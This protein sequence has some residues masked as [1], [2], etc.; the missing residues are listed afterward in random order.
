MDYSNWPLKTIKISDLFL[1]SDNI[2]LDITDPISQDA[3]IN[4]LFANENAIE[5]LENIAINGFFPDELPVALMENNKYIVLEG[6]RRIAAL[7]AL[8]RPEIIPFLEKKIKTII[9]SSALPTEEIKVIM[10]PDRDSAMR[11]LAN[12]HTQITRKPWSPLRQAYFY[13][14]EIDRGKTIQDLRNDYPTVDINKFL[15]MTNMHK[16]VKSI[17]YDSKAIAIKAYSEREFPISTLERMYADK[18][19]RDFLGFELTG[20]GDFEIKIKPDEFKKGLKKIIQDIVEK[21]EN[22]RSLNDEES[23]KKYINSFSA[24]DTPDKTKGTKAIKSGGFKEIPINSNSSKQ[25]RRKLA[26]G[27]IIF[28][29]NSPGVERMLR[30]LQAIDYNRFPNAAHDLLR[31]FLECS[32]KEYFYYI[33]DPIRPAKGRS[34]VFLKDVLKALKDKMDL[35]KNTELSQVTQKIISSEAMEP[36]STKMFDAINHNPSIFS[37]PK[38]VE[39]A[40]DSMEKL[41]RFI[42]NPIIKN[43]QNQP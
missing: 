2:R 33:G 12:K 40:W 9:K 29:L 22:S 41:L 1:D 6:N 17:K 8:A 14:A 13:K 28:T 23:R 16:I 31:S 10:A 7:K 27:N 43:A 42:L 34:Y 39:D 21:K 4:D 30:E 5:I 26:P 11:L 37:I 25:K 32:I 20:D 24:A 15:R 35:E 3:I 18:Y 38:E 19:V 36:H